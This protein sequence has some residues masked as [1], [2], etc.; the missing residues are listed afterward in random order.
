M[1]FYNFWVREKGTLVIE[2]QV[3]ESKCYGKSNTSLED[4]QKDALH[5]LQAVQEKID[6]QR[7]DPD[8]YEVAIREEIIETI[9]KKN[10]ISRNRYGA[11]VLNSENTCFIDIDEPRVSLWKALFTWRK[12]NKQ[13]RILAM[14]E[15]IAAKDEYHALGF[16]VY[17]THSG[18]R[19]IASG[20]DFPAGSEESESLLKAFNSDWL[21][22]ILCKKQQC[23]RARLTPKPVRIKSKTPRIPFPRT[24]EEDLAMKEW[25]QQY[26]EKSAPYSVCRFVKEIGR[27]NSSQIVE[28]HDKYCGVDKNQ[29]LA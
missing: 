22:V 13:E 4:A 27:R 24:T 28:I 19:V 23:Y 2:G 10:I 14:I 8:S 26:R 5:N 29:R 9:D 18:F 25:D 12:M 1:Q 16:R 11:L 3:Q 7:G 15:E 6:G 17:E 21:Y 20:R